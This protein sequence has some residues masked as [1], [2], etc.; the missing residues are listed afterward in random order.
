MKQICRA[1]HLVGLSLS[2]LVL[3]STEPEGTSYMARVHT[4]SG[5]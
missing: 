5:C 2:W 3:R 1:W 4:V